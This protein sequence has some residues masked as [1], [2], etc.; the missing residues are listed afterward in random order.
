MIFVLF[1]FFWGGELRNK[2]EQLLVAVYFVLL[3]VRLS[4][5]LD[6]YL[7]RLAF[8]SVGVGVA[9]GVVLVKTAF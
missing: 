7:L 6:L 8:A 3:T 1:V 2:F 9:V 5:C 4:Y